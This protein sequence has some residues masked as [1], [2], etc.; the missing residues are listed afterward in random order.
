MTNSSDRLDCLEDDLETVKEIMLAV[1]R[2]TE[3]KRYAIEGLTSKLD[4]LTVTVDQF[5]VR[6]D[7]LGIKVD[8]LTAT[9][10]RIAT[11]GE[12]DRAV[13]LGMLEDQAELRREN[14]QILDYLMRRDR[15]G[16]DNGDQS[17]P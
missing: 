9:V 12:A 10:E 11:D 1:A 16:N 6:V 2:R 8:Q 7:Q 14:R 15:N 3:S 4:R 17:Q 5:G 13:M